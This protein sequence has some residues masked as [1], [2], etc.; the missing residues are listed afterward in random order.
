MTSNLEESNLSFY[1]VQNPGQ[2]SWVI[3]NHLD[4]KGN[5]EASKNAQ[6]KFNFKEDSYK[7]KANAG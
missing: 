5:E 6:D 2:K 7:V 4:E 3:T 1:S